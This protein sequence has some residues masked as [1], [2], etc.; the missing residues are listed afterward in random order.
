MDNN[1]NNREDDDTS[2][3]AQR[4]TAHTIASIMFGGAFNP[5]Q[6]NKVE[7]FATEKA[8]EMRTERLKRGSQHIAAECNFGDTPPTSLRR[9]V[10]PRKIHSV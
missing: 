7:T 1:N 6:W 10:K 9:I 5:S 3:G 8:R 4:R 2:M